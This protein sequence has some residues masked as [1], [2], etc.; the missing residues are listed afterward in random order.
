[1]T[2]L[3][4]AA[5]ALVLALGCACSP[6]GGSAQEAPGTARVAA[7]SDLRFALEALAAEAPDLEL[8][9]TYGSSGQLYQQISNGAP[10]D[11]FLSA[12][13]E[14]AQRL[15]DEGRASGEPFEY[16]VGRLALL[17]PQGSPVDLQRGLAAL[18]DP[19]VRTVSIANP[20]HAPYGR[21][22]QAALDSAGVLAAVQSK[23]V[24]GENVSQAAEFVTSG[25]AQAGVVALSLAVAPG[26]AD[27]SE[28]VEV[29]RSLFPPL[30]QG[31]V[32]L[33]GAQDA[34]A[35]R[36]LRTLLLSDEGQ[37]LLRRNGFDLPEDGR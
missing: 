10:Y 16:A 28:H 7:A 15:A 3:R 4:V 27:R 29:A 20:E 25:N 19:Q 33:T 30:R 36:A 13:T 32:V 35:A 26:L 17:V 18:A 24:L 6:A 2:R 22:A 11:V 34:D 9:V 12:D 23:L 37:E 8:A 5:L 14:L 21:A 31:G 1:V